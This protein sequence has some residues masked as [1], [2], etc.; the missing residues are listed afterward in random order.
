MRGHGEEFNVFK[1]YKNVPTWY[2][3]F[4]GIN[5]VDY[6]ETFSNELINLVKGNPGLS[7]DEDFRANLADWS[8]SFRM[9]TTGKSAI[10]GTQLNFDDFKDLAGAIREWVSTYNEKN[11]TDIKIFAEIAN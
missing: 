7:G 8:H 6:G 10:E 5:R 11:E 4:E 1:N 2:D 9:N 3:E